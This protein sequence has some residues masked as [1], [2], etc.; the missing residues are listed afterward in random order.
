MELYHIIVL[1]EK[2]VIRQE[3]WIVEPEIVLE[4]H[5]FK[6][7]LDILVDVA[8]HGPDADGTTGRT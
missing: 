1:V 3:D 7:L 2:L 4:F 8:A 5:G 6:D